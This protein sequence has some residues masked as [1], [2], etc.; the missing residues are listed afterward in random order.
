MP[1]I[2]M[3]KMHT[4][5]TKDYSPFKEIIM[6]TE[7][8]SCTE[9]LAKCEARLAAARLN[10][11]E[12]TMNVDWYVNPSTPSSPADAEYAQAYR[13]LVRAELDLEYAHR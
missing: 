5:L 9:T 1:W 8:T 13:A 2:I 7:I 10:A 6:N 11:S 4:T 3:L 12:Q